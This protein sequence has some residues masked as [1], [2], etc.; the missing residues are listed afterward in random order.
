RA[1]YQP[2][3]TM[4]RFAHRQPAW[5]TIS[6]VLLSA[7]LLSP[8]TGAALLHALLQAMPQNGHATNSATGS[9]ATT[10]QA[11]E[12]APRRSAQEDEDAILRAAST[13]R[14]QLQNL[15]EG[16]DGEHGAAAHLAADA[17]LVTLRPRTVL[18][19]P[20]DGPGLAGPT[21]AETLRSRFVVSPA[22][23]RAPPFA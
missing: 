9:D 10:R 15:R 1:S 22:S 19:V 8:M 16:K 3:L 7:L 2:P 20:D 14:S 21:P 6:V 12:T 23:P 18:L 17:L 11:P 4:S 13:L 5:G